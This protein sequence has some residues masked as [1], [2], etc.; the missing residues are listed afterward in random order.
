MEYG[1]ASID[2]NDCT[3]SNAGFI[4]TNQAGSSIVINGSP[5]NT[6]NFNKSQLVEAGFAEGK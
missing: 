4:A 5:Q 6:T 3:F 1:A 2:C